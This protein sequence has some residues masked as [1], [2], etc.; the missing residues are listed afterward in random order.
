MTAADMARVFDEFTQGTGSSRRGQVGTGLGLPIVRR[1]A[2]LMRGE[3]TLR[4]APEG[5]VLPG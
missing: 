4:A 3:V 5:G 2:R 1:L